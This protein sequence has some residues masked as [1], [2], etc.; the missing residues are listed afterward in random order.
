MRTIR[1]LLLFAAV[2]ALLLGAWACAEDN[3]NREFD[4]DDDDDSFDDDIDDDDATP[5][6]DTGDD[7]TGDDD[8]LDDDTIDDDTGDDDTIDDDTIDDDDDTPPPPTTD[9]ARAAGFKLFYRERVDRLILS[10][11]RFG[12][13]GDAVAATNIGKH[14]IAKSGNEYEVLGG[15]TDNNDIGASVFATWYAYQAFG[16]RNL[17][18][19]LIRQF[20]GLA[21]YEAVTGHTGLTSREVL[22]G[23]TRTMDGVNDTIYRTRDG[24]NPFT[25][26]VVFSTALEQEILDTFYD[27][28]VMTYRE[29]PLEYYPNFRSTS[30][31]GDYAVTY[32]FSDPPTYL[33]IS[34][35]CSSWKISQ[36]GTWEGA[37]WGN[38][39]SRDNFPDMSFG[40]LAA[41]EAA[42]S[43]DLPADLA[44]AVQEALEAGHR[45][46][47]RITADDNV[48][49]TVPEWEDYN[50]LM[51][52]GQIRPDG[53]TEWQDLGSLASCPM[54][55]MAKALSTDGLDAPLPVL[56]LPGSIEMSA[57]RY[58]LELIGMPGVPLPVLKCRSIDDAF[59][60]MTWGDLLDLEIFG[61]PWY[62]IAF[63]IAEIW[64]DLFP[65][66]LGSTGDDFKEMELAVMAL[67]QYAEIYQKDDLYDLAQE[68]MQN[69][70]DIHRILAE[71]AYSAAASPNRQGNPAAYD[72][73]IKGAEEHLYVAAIIA[74]QF[75]IEA[76]DEDLNDFTIGH[77]RAA[78]I[79]NILSLGDTATWALKTDEE[80]MAAIQAELDSKAEKEPWIV[81]RYWERFP[82]DP[83][84]RRNGDGYEAINLDG[85]WQ[86]VENPWHAWYGASKLMF[87]ASLCTKSPWTLSCDW[88]VLG[89]AR[90]DLDGSGAVD[91]ADRT[92][93]D[94]AY[95]TYSGETCD[96]GNSWCEGAD[97]DRSGAADE[98]D[99][100]FIEAADGC[101][102]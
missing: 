16:G 97:L 46:G 30:E 42:Q 60:G 102:Y 45:I 14:N 79:E 41:M 59:V 34:N 10:W 44:Q 82:E 23:W 11:N 91:A 9:E 20:E 77:Q 71:L 38:H 56:P 101:W 6:D 57:I 62:E 47:D 63:A 85:E 66:L 89:C 53:Q 3:D 5:D 72:E 86:S 39:N 54:A 69:L 50:E 4:D 74:R 92:L 28:I 2:L 43:K 75:G 99:T 17:E 31:M 37:F 88:A 48:Q 78:N 32:V 87:E 51:P 61:V 15:E 49:M 29:N 1:S 95:A 52:G 26:P 24:I 94:A 12:L 40:F 67:C 58:L 18:L 64:P 90:P 55:Y 22:P 84:I 33:H 7:D 98:S 76:P 100:A 68:T 70:I 73:M 80:I 96:E 21:F 35:C 19:T 36:I 93:F 25:P 65:D 13:A 8:T 81:A 27:D 83:P